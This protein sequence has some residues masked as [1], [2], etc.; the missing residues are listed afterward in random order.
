MSSREPLRDI[1]PV[2]EKIRHGAAAEIPIP[3]PMRV[4]IRVELDDPPRMPR[5]RFQSSLETSKSGGAAWLV[6]WF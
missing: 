4:L 2:N 1:Y 5:K 6:M 3:A